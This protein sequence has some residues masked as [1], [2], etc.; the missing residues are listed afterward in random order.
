MTIGNKTIKRS[1]KVQSKY[2]EILGNVDD[3]KKKNSYYS[4]GQLR[5]GKY[6][7]YRYEKRF[8]GLVIYDQ[9]VLDLLLRG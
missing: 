6:L 3:L 9:V 7:K 2:R 4:E 5:C 1:T 8:F